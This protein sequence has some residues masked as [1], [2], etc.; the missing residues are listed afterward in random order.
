M[1]RTLATL[2]SIALLLSVIIIGQPLA[3][4][5]TQ[6]RAALRFVPKRIKEASKKMRYTITARYPQAVGATRDARL[7]ALNQQLKELMEKEVADFKKDYEPP[8]TPM[9]S[10]G[11]YYDAGYVVSLAT[12][13]LVSIHFGVNTYGEGAAHPNNNSLVFNYDLQS[14]KQLNLS[15]LFK[16]NSNYLSLISNYAIRNLKKQLGPD[17]DSDWIERGAGPSEENFKAWTLTR[18]GLSIMFDAYQVASYAEGP[19]DV[20]IPYSVLKSAIDPAGPLARIVK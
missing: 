7:A 15:D 17:P 6:R 5:A 13:D 16:P 20:L 3:A 12:N 11:S 14:G 19:H 1:K 2:S 18:R 8:D 9:S 10:M 4:A